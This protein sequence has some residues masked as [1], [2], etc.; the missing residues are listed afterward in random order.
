MYSQTFSP[1]NLYLCS[2][3]SER[4]NS[5]LNKDNFVQK[6]ES[7]IGNTINNGTF[8]F[9]IKHVSDIYL[10]DCSKGTYE[11]ICQDLVLR[12]LYRNIKRIYGVRQA[13][14]N[15]IVRQMKSLLQEDSTKWVVRLDVRHFYESVERDR[16][17]CRFK[18][19]GRLNY[20]SIS[21]LEN[22]FSQPLFSSIRGLPRGLSISSVMSE[23][24]LK[25]FDLEVRRIEGVFYYARFVDD[26][27]VFCSSQQSQE[28]VWS[29]VPYILKQIGLELN[30][31]KSYKWISNTPQSVL[32]Y[33]GYSFNQ[34]SK[35]QVEISIADRK[36]NVIKSRLTRSFV[37]Y[38]KDGDFVK[39]KNRIK[40]LTGNITLYNQSTLLP[41]NVGIYYNY[42][43]VTNKKT[44]YELDK[45]YQRI[46]HC[47]NGKLGAC[48]NSKMTGIQRTELTKYSF[49]FGF[50][51][52]VHHYFSSA[53]LVELTDCWQ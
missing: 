44:L 47:R 7:C 18:E 39:L 35:K 12:K 51:N 23:L 52:R 36:V 3:Q 43:M 5:G 30:D 34:K 37:R 48:L 28:K 32:T 25:Y 42:N 4:R 29:T 27:I 15:Q 2:S 41:I 22:L 21:L 20:Q 16:L 53:M 8:Q 13:N 45:Y 1:Q 46:L 6:V 26:I 49:V 33:L 50:N 19:D 11:Y 31:A 24:Y 14:R 17:I 38:A 10:N 40:F 9:K